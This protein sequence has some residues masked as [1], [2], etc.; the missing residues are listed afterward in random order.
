MSHHHHHGRQPHGHSHGTPSADSHDGRS[1][2]A[3]IFLNIAFVGVE[4]S[5]GWH[6]G[7]MALIADAGHN[8]S[9]VLALLAAW[10]ALML[11]RRPS[12]ARFTYGLGRASVLAALANSV[13]L[14]AACGAIAWE[15]LGRLRSAPEVPGGVVMSV[16]AAGILVNGLS[17]LMLY[18]HRT[19]DLNMRAAF[20]HMLADLAV[21]VGVLAAGALIVLTGAEWID[22][23]VSL[24]VVGVVLLGSWSLLRDSLHLSLDGVPGGIDSAAIKQF[25]SKQQGVADVHD[26]HIWAL[27]TT[28]VAL[29]AHLVVPAGDPRGALLR[30]LRGSLQRDFRIDHATLQIESGD[31]ELACEMRT[32]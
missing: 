24:L 9:D 25:L 21:S 17:A 14:L 13:L 18:R 28:S 30:T 26:L 20:L 19:H 6:S 11:A 5:Y 15:S 3:A 12:G 32:A 10:G 7:S 23:A 1:V 4:A 31:C 16:A 29:T 8:L 22:P 27:S 2:A